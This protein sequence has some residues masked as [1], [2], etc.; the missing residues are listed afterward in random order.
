MAED[1]CG[2]K[3]IIT[4]LLISCLINIKSSNCEHGF[5]NR[6]SVVMLEHLLRIKLEGPCDLTKFKDHYIADCFHIWFDIQR[7]N[8]VI[9]KKP[10]NYT[11]KSQNKEWKWLM[12]GKCLNLHQK[13]MN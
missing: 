8:K 13:L 5:S 6:L 2:R 3:N 10:E 9:Y 4:C 12:S 1:K 7:R 11:L